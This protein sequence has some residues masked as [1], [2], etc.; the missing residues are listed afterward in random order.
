M[1]K[2]FLQ[3]QVGCAGKNQMKIIDFELQFFVIIKPRCVPYILIDL[4][5]YI[6]WMSNESS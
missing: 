1:K 5:I 6:Y 3:I 2:F 4:Y